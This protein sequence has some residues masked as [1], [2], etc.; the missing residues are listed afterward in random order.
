MVDNTMVSHLARISIDER[1]KS[2]KLRGGKHRRSGKAA[3]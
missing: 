2:G 1:S 3:S